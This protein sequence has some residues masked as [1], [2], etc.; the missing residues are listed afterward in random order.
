MPPAALETCIAS[1]LSRLPYWQAAI[2]HA[3]ACSPG[4]RTTPAFAEGFCTWE[5]GAS[6]SESKSLWFL[7][8][9]CE[10]V[11]W[12][13][14][15]HRRAHA[16]EW[17]AVTSTTA[18]TLRTWMTHRLI[19]HLRRPR[20]LISDAIDATLVSDRWKIR[21]GNAPNGP[22]AQSLQGLRRGVSRP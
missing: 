19:V 20:D 10:Q 11:V 15:A 14:G 1:P 13:L 8:K 22:Q 21:R 17:A 4:K 9:V 2:L 7:A 3:E 18:E 6:K 12:M 5:T 16:S